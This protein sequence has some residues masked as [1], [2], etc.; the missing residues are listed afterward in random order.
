MYEHLNDIY[1]TDRLEARLAE[2]ERHTVT[3][4]IA[5]M[6]YGKTT[7]IRHW[8]AR[9][10]EAHPDAIIL[11]Q[12]IFND[13]VG[14]LWRD[15]CRLLARHDAPLAEQLGRAGFPQ[16]LQGCG[17]TADLWG[18]FR[19]AG[20]PPVWWIV[21]DV[22]LL[23]QG[24]LVPLAAFLPDG[25]EGL[26]MVLLSRN[27]IV[28]RP[29]QMRMGRHLCQIR[30]ND[31]ALTELE[32]RQYVGLCGLS[33]DDEDAARMMKL[34]EG[35][36]GLI[37]LFLRSRAQEGSWGFDTPDVFALI[38]QVML[39][40]LSDRERDFLL[41]CSAA[42]EFTPEQ[43]AFLWEGRGEDA[44]AL[45]TALSENNA[46]I[47]VNEEG[48]YRFHNM[49][50]QTVMRH[51]EKL[52]AGEQRAIFARLGGWHFRQ[53]EYLKAMHAYRKAGAWEYLL[54]AV[55]ADMGNSLDGEQRNSLL[56]WCANCPEELLRTHPEAMLI[57]TLGCFTVGAI[58]EMLRMN[59]LMLDATQHNPALPKEE[60][61]NYLGESQVLMSFLQF[62][63]ITGMSEY[64]RRAGELMNRPT[65]CLDLKS[66]WTF[67]APSILSLYHRDSGAL[68][69]ENEKMRD[70]MP[71]YERISEGHGRGAEYIFEA[72]TRFFRGD[73]DGAKIA[74]HRAVERAEEKE[75]HSILAAAAFL[76]VR[77]DMMDGNLDRVKSR[78]KTLRERLRRAG[79]FFLLTAADMCEAW[80]YALLGR[81]EYTPDWVVDSPAASLKGPAWASFL[82]VRDQVLLAWGDY[83]QLIASGEKQAAFF[84]ETHA[85]LPSIYLHIQF[86]AAYL[87]L[88]RGEDAR[89][90]LK[91]ALA[92]AIPDRLWLPF[93]ENGPYIGELLGRTKLPREA[94]VPL[95][96]MTDRFIRAREAILREHFPSVWDAGLTDRER[97]VADLA[98]R[99]LSV[100]EISEAL[101]LSENTVK[102]HLRHIY[103]KLNIT[104]A[105]RNK[106]AALEGVLEEKSPL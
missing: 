12:S 4:V 40:P 61:N 48:R 45:L 16:D 104:G 75:Q 44:E 23:P 60:R 64:Q 13:S 19:P 85:M 43:A 11:R 30:M 73:W 47:T 86:A 105:E 84:T 2:I 87:G 67:G 98:A 34:S 97:K 15:F 38:E 74:W 71:W 9:T 81:P 5:P 76:A 72:E 58:S 24:A 68:D 42:E 63:S 66:P 36:I 70:C 103:N 41:K 89:R 57:L 91:Q 10:T 22:H 1:I 80:C 18:E 14:D 37:Y 62:N 54:K 29:E 17:L 102:T 95:L 27:R 3:T 55:V 52:P 21:D 26:H 69:E 28:T 82:T 79:Q 20:S 8:Q 25:L 93:A 53:G 99:R 59:E 35:W 32:M 83:A 49:L 33:L 50:L 96:F 65:R 100:R 90:E 92:L 51:F 56:D 106:R 46:F 94:R 6:G 31:L 77:M 101:Q 7:A 39:E 88:N 78:I